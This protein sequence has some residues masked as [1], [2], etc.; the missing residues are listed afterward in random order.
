MIVCSCN[1]LS[2]VDVRTALNVE[3]GPRSPGEVYG[4]LG[5]T[6]QGGRCSPTLREVM[7]EAGR[8][9]PGPAGNSCGWLFPALPALSAPHTNGGPCRVALQQPHC[10]S[11]S[12]S[13]ERVP[14]MWTQQG[15][16]S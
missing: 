3:A 11:S 4:C 5:C 16:R 7:D 1:V 10:S 6:P 9:R 2:D 14:K 15:L 12:L 13:I 8:R